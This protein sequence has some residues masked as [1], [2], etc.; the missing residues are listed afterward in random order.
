MAGLIVC[1]AAGCIPTQGR[2]DPHG[3]CLQVIQ[4][5][6]S[7]RHYVYELWRGGRV[8][9]YTPYRDLADALADDPAARA[10]EL[11]AHKL[12]IAGVPFALAGIALTALSSVELVQS[13]R[14]TPPQDG[15]GWRGG[16]AAGVLTFA[17]GV[18]TAA[19]G[20]AI[21]TRAIHRY[22]HWAEQHGCD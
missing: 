13:S 16:L 17:A 2:Y 19:A 12:E 21:Q 1:A 9:S 22:D 15:A 14:A 8:Y 5:Y 4:R 6:V 10:D 20:A 3:P 11:L 7:R 18:A